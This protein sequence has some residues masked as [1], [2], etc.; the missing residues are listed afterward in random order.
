MSQPSS[1][2]RKSS[3]VHLIER[4]N[5]L[6]QYGISMDLSEELEES[7][8]DRCE[9][10]LEGARTP[11]HYPGSAPSQVQTI[12]R[13]VQ[14]L[15]E[16]RLHRDITP[17]IVPSAE[18]AYRNGEIIPHYLVDEVQ[19]EWTRCA[20]MGSTRPKPDLTVGLS[21]ND[22]TEEETQKLKARSS[23][24][25]PSF[26]APNLCYPFIM[27]EAKTLNKADRQDVHSAGIA[28]NAIIELQKAAFETTEPDRVQALF[29]KP[30]V[31]SVSHNG[32]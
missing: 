27:A 17:W 13:R 28:V 4:I 3:S 30:L 32:R 23:L 22:F 21:L 16:G 19:A 24:G 6:S 7:G 14:D 11:S 8:K 10:F 20:P 15:N 25:R 18:N 12:L 29:R 1:I 9:S 26:V 31:F 5:R 2:K